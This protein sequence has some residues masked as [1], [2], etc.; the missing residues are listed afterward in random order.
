MEREPFLADVK[1]SRRST[2]VELAE[3]LRD[4]ILSG[5]IPT[6]APLRESW[7]AQDIG[8]S[9][10]TVRE[11]LFVLVAEGLL[12]H[13]PHHGFSVVKLSPEDLADLYRARRVMELAA[14]DALP[15]DRQDAL[16][17][18]DA[19]LDH[20]RRAAAENDTTDAY[21]A[22]LEIHQALV[23]TLGSPRLDA[24]FTGILKELRPAIIVMDTLSDFPELV[25]EHEQLVSLIRAG[26]K[27][28]ASAHLKKH[29]DDAERL[30][31]AESTKPATGLGPATFGLGSGRTGTAD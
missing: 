24:V 21:Q 27:A 4:R 19:A 3:A 1:I 14:L 26:D 5:E 15:P 17:G 25:A 31:V 13:L 9:R 28:S 6:G 30:L 29:L 18:V 23:A 11:A 10:N 2:V 16:K 22:D 8:V 12:R 7:I 20:L